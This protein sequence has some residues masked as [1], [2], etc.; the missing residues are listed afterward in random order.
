MS[1]HRIRLRGGW[2]MLEPDEPKSPPRLVTLPI[3]LEPRS[4]GRLVFVRRFGR[5]AHDPAQQ[6]VALVLERVPGLARIR[7]NGRDRP[8]LPID[9]FVLENL[10]LAERNVLVLEVEPETTGAPRDDWGHVALVVGPR[11]PA[12]DRHPLA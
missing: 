2:E 11:S 9:R 7:L 1:D 12:G 8:L 3:A 10:E 6:Q 4:T 5:P